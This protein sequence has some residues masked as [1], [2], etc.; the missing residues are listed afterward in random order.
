MHRRL[1]TTKCSSSQYQAQMI[2][3]QESQH[4]HISSE[5]MPCSN[6][7]DCKPGNEEGFATLNPKS[8]HGHRG[9]DFH[10]HLGCA[11][12]A[13]TADFAQHLSIDFF[14]QVLDMWKYE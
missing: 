1:Q 8:E 11:A 9:C 6:L 5:V 4:K 13:P 3:T 10:E 2:P 12:D 14:Q 7:K